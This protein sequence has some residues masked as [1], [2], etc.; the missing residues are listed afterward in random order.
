MIVMPRFLSAGLITMSSFLESSRMNSL[1]ERV[2]LEGKRGVFVKKLE[3]QRVE[4]RD[5]VYDTNFS[6]ITD[7]LGGFQ[8]EG[9]CNLGLKLELLVFRQWNLVRILLK[10]VDK[11]RSMSDL[12]LGRGVGMNFSPFASVRV[13][14]DVRT[15]ELRL[16]MFVLV[17]I[18]SICAGVLCPNRWSAASY[19]VED[20][21]FRHRDLDR[22]VGPSSFLN[23]N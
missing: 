18:H 19:G 10:N 3:L 4:Y 8:V 22:D 11:L 9:M 7:P 2:R 17:R 1:S 6:K 5:W 23:A 13:W 15:I 21:G 12:E 14:C 20:L 16:W